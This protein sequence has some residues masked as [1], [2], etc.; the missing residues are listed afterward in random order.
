MNY[1][2]KYFLHEFSLLSVQL[3]TFLVPYVLPLPG[4]MFCNPEGTTEK[5]SNIS[6]FG[7]ELLLQF[8]ESD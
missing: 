4:N 1:W 6:A 3:T 8:P 7:S 2:S 5:Q